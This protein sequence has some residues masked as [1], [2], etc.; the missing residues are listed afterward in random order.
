M[1]T[2]GP[3]ESGPQSSL[4]TAVGADAAYTVAPTRDCVFAEALDTARII[5]GALAR[6]ESFRYLQS[7]VNDEGARVAA[8]YIQRTLPDRE[9]RHKLALSPGLRSSALR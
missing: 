3:T 2:T 9:K 8:R 4:A 5:E 1:L 7:K 6:A